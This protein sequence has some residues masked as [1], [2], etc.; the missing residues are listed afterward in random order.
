M[1]Q[2]ITQTPKS[3]QVQVCTNESAFAVL[4]NAQRLV[5]E[6]VL[7]Q[8]PTG[9]RYFAQVANVYKDLV[10]AYYKYAEEDLVPVS[11]ITDAIVEHLVYV[12]DA[13]VY[14][15]IVANTDLASIDLNDLTYLSN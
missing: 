1:L 5:A 12:E 14:A 7:E 9:S 2:T 4:E 6:C 13:S 11:A 10:E 8:D 3:V 15:D